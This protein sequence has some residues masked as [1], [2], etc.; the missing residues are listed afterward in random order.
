MSESSMYTCSICSKKYKNSRSLASHR[1]TQHSHSS[2][3]MDKKYIPKCTPTTK[4]KE[5]E[6]DLNSNHPPE[7]HVIESMDEDEPDWSDEKQIVS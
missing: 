2:V 3:G 6:F 4:G 1:Y 5:G 7:P